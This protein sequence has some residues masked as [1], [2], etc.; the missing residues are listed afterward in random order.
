M[1]ALLQRT[2]RGF[3]AAFSSPQPKHHSDP[4][5]LEAIKRW[6]AEHPEEQAKSRLGAEQIS[7]GR[8]RTISRRETNR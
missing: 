1:L 4:D 2:V 7:Q 5:R 3:M 8:S 6:I